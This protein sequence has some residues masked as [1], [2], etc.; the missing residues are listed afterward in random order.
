MGSVMTKGPEGG[1][2]R[3]VLSAKS[4]I[5]NNAAKVLLMN[6]P[7]AGMRNGFVDNFFRLAFNGDFAGTLRLGGGT[8]SPSGG[9]IRD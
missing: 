4:V 5:N 2:V 6:A 1:A 3:R 9:R 7:L 8:R